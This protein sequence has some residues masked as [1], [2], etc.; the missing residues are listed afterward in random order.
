MEGRRRPNALRR[1]VYPLGD[2]HARRPQHARADARHGTKI[3][4]NL[5]QMPRD[6]QMLQRQRPKRV[7]RHAAVPD[8]GDQH[9][10]LPG[11]QGAQK[12]RDGAHRARRREAMSSVRYLP[13]GFPSACSPLSSNISTQWTP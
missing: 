3:R 5:A 2:L 7:R 10:P 4:Q 13:R 1:A 6:E 12:L 9:R 8:P 11:Q